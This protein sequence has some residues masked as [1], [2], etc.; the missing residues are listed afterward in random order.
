M[1]QWQDTIS[2]QLRT[3]ALDQKLNVRILRQILLGLGQQLGVTLLLNLRRCRG[4]RLA[5]HD[6]DLHRLAQMLGKSLTQGGNRL[7]GNQVA[8][9]RRQS[10]DPTLAI[11]LPAGMQRQ[12]A[13]TA[14]DATGGNQLTPRIATTQQQILRVPAFV[15]RSCR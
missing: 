8:M 2:I 12:L 4:R 14:A 10:Q 7:V 1:L 15:A 9:F 6:L 3:K 13:Q 5:L 11:D